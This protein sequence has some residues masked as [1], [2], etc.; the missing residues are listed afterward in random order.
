MLMLMN[1]QWYQRL[2]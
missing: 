1:I 2:L